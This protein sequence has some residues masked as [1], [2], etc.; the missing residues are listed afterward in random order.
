MKNVLLTGATGNLGSLIARELLARGARLRLLVRP[1]SAGK[2]AP[3][4]AAAAEVAEDE[5]T[6][7]KDIDTVVSAVQG[8]PETI[9][10]AQLRWLESARAAGAR[11]FIPSDYSFDLFR[12]AEGQNLNSDWRRAFARE[13]AARRG[14]VEVVHVLNGCFLDHRVLF[15]FL[16]MFDLTQGQASY[17]GSGNEPMD[18]TTYADTAAYTAEAALDPNPVGPTLMVAGATL[19]FPQLVAEVEAGLGVRLEVIRRGSL[20]ELDETIA[21][22]QAAE[23]QNFFAWLPLMYQRGMLSGQGRLTELRNSRYPGIRPL[24]VQDY[25]RA[26]A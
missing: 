14:A 2:L 26:P 3:E 13:A 23:P 12:L 11:R 6:A 19:D 17:W 25:L 7:F 24:G 4:L 18:F 16:G 21:R 8:G 22:A 1:G 20:E 10:D 5:A 15:G 9:V